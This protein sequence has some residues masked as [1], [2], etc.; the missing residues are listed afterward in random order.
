MKESPSKQATIHDVQQPND[1]ER[2]G[3]KLDGC[4][5]KM[6]RTRPLTVPGTSLT[7]L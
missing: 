1:A 7:N 2:N 3:G 5:F 4:G 6:R